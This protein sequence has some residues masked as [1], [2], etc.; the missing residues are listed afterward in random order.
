MIITSLKE[1]DAINS[2]AF[3]NLYN[4]NHEIFIKKMNFLENLNVIESKKS[5]IYF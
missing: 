1:Y 4:I 2:I 5:E 3:C